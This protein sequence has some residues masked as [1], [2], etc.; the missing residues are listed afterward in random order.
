MFS[1]LNI[2]VLAPIKY[3]DGFSHQNLKFSTLIA[4]GLMITYLA[5]LIIFMFYMTKLWFQMRKNMFF[6][7]RGYKALNPWKILLF[8]VLTFIYLIS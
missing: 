8:Y 3:Y 6:F 7:T 2:I 4:A 1:V 5:I